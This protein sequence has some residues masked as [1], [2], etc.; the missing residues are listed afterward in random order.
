M[1][2]NV[3]AWGW[4]PPKLWADDS[5]TPVVM[6]QTTAPVQPNTP[7]QWDV[8]YQFNSI[9]P[10]K[11]KVQNDDA[12]ITQKVFA[13]EPPYHDSDEYRLTEAERWA[14]EAE[15][16]RDM[17]KATPWVGD[18]PGNTAGGLTVKEPATRQQDA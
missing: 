17:R 7:G 12:Y 13:G 2:F 4:H 9:G 11:L 16:A 15:K 6:T 10:H 3:T 1:Q 8:T 14:R 5:Q 18:D